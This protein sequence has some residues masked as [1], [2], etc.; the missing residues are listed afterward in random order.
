MCGR[1]SQVDVDE[2]YLRVYGWPLPD[3]KPRRNIKP[4]E[5]V[6]IFVYEDREIK[7]VT[8]RWWAESGSS[9][10]RVATT[11]ECFLAT[12]RFP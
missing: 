10:S 2:Y 8:A 4:T 11:P 7:P 5:E 9:I 12:A 6:P 3:Y 1:I